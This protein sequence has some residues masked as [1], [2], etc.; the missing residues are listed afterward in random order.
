MNSMDILNQQKS[1]LPK[2]N[3]GFTN[4][5]SYIDYKIDQIEYLKTFN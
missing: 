2:L 5:R 1:R 4:R 3:Q